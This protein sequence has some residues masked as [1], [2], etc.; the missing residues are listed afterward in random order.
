[1]ANETTERA[2]L[3]ELLAQCDS[4]IERLAE[5]MTAEIAKAHELRADIQTAIEVRS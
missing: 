2:Q 4:M 5:T 1:M 3:V